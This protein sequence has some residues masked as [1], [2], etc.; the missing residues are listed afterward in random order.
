MSK[1]FWRWRKRFALFPVSINGKHVWLK[2]YWW[3]YTAINGPL[4][5]SIYRT[6]DVSLIGE[7][8]DEI[9]KAEI[10]KYMGWI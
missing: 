9:V 1:S 8:T 3:R 10:A 6:Q 4:Q 5:P 2:W 7:N